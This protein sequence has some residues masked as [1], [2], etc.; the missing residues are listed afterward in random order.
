MPFTWEELS[1]IFAALALGGLVKG[2]TGMGLP[3]VTVP[4]LAE[5]LGVERAV[6][7]M[8]I[9]TLVLNAY[10]IWTHRDARSEVPELPRFLLAGIP[11]AAFGAT[12]LYLAS[13]RFL[14]AALGIWLLGYVLLRLAHPSFSLPMASRMRWSPVIG[15]GAGALQAATGIAAPI[16]APY[17]DALRLRPH[18]Y[19]FAVSAPFGAFAAAHLAIVIGSRLYT[20][21]LLTQSLLAVI[22]AAAFTPA[23]M[24][25]RRFVSQSTFDVLIRVTLVVMSL[26]LIY[27]SWL[28]T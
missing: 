21:E 27:V 22:P 20:P 25:L 8:I 6:L 9:P 7:T 2:I 13:E 1:I 3:L 15:A 11:G 19:V 4:V 12:V 14:S 26:R 10:Q 24:W 18:V 28:G 5:F 16:V 17:A 23:G